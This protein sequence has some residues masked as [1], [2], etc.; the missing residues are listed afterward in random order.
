MASILLQWMEPPDARRFLLRMAGGLRHLF[1]G[2]LI[3]TGVPI[4]LIMLAVWL[5][6]LVAGANVM[7]FPKA[8]LLFAALSIA[9]SVLVS[10]LYLAIPQVRITSTQIMVGMHK[11]GKQSL[12]G[13][14]WEAHSINGTEYA[15][16]HLSTRG[17][18]IRVALST[19]L[20]R[21]DV[22]RALISLG[23]QRTEHSSNQP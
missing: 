22:E 2:D 8:L 20:P 11:W 6:A 17:R 1:L 14:D 12:R 4:I 3:A 5:F 10:V 23:L 15:V 13:Y 7:P 16:L 18:P 9:V 21:E 19:D